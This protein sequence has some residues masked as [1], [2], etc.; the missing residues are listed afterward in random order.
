M[1]WYL[2]EVTN[3]I[4]KA[5]KKGGLQP[6]DPIEAYIRIDEKSPLFTPINTN[7]PLLRKAVKIPVAF[8]QY[9]PEY[10]SPVVTTSDNNV[11]G[12]GNKVEVFLLPTSVHFDAASIKKK[13]GLG[14]KNY[15]YVT[16]SAGLLAYASN[17]KELEGNI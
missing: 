6:Y 3:R 9:K 12:K 11:A 5:K 15:S 2:R 4:Q 7:L 16:Q 14:E 8:V 17:K 13:F 10:V 1:K